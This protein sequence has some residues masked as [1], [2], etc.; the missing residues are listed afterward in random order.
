M[1]ASDFRNISG[2]SRNT[3]VRQPFRNTPAWISGLS[4]VLLFS[5]FQAVMASSFLAE[6]VE[7]ARALKVLISNYFP[8][9]FRKL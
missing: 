1:A 9:I 4:G 5:V 2:T 8:N 6:L 3:F 7:I